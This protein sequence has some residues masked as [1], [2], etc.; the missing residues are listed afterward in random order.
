MTSDLLT[1]SEVTAGLGIVTSNRSSQQVHVGLRCSISKTTCLQES[2]WKDISRLAEC[3]AHEG[4]LQSSLL[5]LRMK[6][7]EWELSQKKWLQRLML[8]LSNDL[9]VDRTPNTMDIVDESRDD[10]PLS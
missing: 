10:L 3:G 4:H 6:L 8:E 5:E 2:R 7:E 9:V 1:T